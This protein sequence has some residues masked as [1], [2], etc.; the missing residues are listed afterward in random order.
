MES[1]IAKALK[2]FSKPWGQCP[3]TS[4]SEMM[5]RLF[6]SCPAC[7]SDLVGHSW[8]KLASVILGENDEDELEN[9][10]K[11]RKWMEAQQIHQWSG[12][13]DERE[14]YVLR[15]PRRDSLSLVSVI[16]LADIWLDDHVER[17]EVLDENDTAW[18]DGRVSADAWT[19]L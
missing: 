16:S 12:N 14:F 7:E 18:F 8:W 2:Y 1:T 13:R 5:R 6:V 4:T 11:Q 9:L 3:D 10:V 17:T 19:P 15:C